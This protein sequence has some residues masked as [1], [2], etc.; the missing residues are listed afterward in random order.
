MAADNPALDPV[1]PAAPPDAQREAWRRWRP[2]LRAWLGPA[3]DI[4]LDLAGVRASS[5]LLDLAGG[6]GDH[7]LRI[8]ERVELRGHVLALEPNLTLATFAAQAARDGGFTNVEAQ[9]LASRR[10]V[11][12]EG[13]DAA[14]SRLGLTRLEGLPRLLEAVGAALQPGGRLAAMVLT[15]AEGNPL[16]AQPLAAA[17]RHAPEAGAA[18]QRLFRLGTPANLEAAFRAAGFSAMASRAQA[19]PLRLPSLDE[20]VLLLR[21]CCGPLRSV[22]SGLAAE[23]VQAV[24]DETGSA[25]A[26]FAG[27][28]GVTVPGEV[29]VCVGTKG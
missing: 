4:M 20:A 12:P 1:N 21:E 5:R 9:H 15:T 17:A 28:E 19:A 23:A 8:A 24:W 2:T 10:L 27:R 29:L 26:A 11:V 14:V 6:S 18:L 7:A 22:L 3:T 25:L 13:Y 16:F